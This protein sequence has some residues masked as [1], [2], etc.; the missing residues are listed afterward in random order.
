MLYI[1]RTLGACIWGVVVDM[2]KRIDEL[3]LLQRGAGSRG[4]RKSRGGGH[5]SICPPSPN[6]IELFGCFV[7]ISRS[8]LS[9]L[10]KFLIAVNLAR[11][12]GG[13]RSGEVKG[14]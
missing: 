7:P 1:A 6:Q 5:I 3:T 8:Q 9:F 13:E 14:I 10:L 11:L 2:V 12:E 4:R